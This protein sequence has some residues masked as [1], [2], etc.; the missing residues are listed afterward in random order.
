MKS[1][2]VDFQ[3]KRPVYRI[4]F[5]ISAPKA[6]IFVTQMEFFLKVFNETTEFIDFSEEAK[7]EI[8][9]AKQG[10]YQEV[11]VKAKTEFEKKY[12]QN[13]PSDP[14]EKM[15]EYKFL[16]ILGQGAFGL[17][18]IFHSSSSFAS[19]FLP[20]RHSLLETRRAQAD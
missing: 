14:I 3:F 2:L 18:V 10:Q 9:A 16:A 17:V 5:A 7:D 13:P 8:M 15:R 1:N 4:N 12:T 11:I 20:A 6:S 19:D